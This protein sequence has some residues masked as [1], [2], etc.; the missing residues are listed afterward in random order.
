MTRATTALSGDLRVAAEHALLAPSIHNTQPW[1]FV[2]ADGAL[3]I[4]ADRGRQLSVLDP[5]GRQLMISCGCAVFNA[6]VSLA[7]AGYDVAVER[8]PDPNR[9][10]LVARLR[11]PTHTAQWLRLGD[12]D[13]YVIHRQT[14]RRHFDDEQVHPSVVHDLVDAVSAEGARLLQ[15]TD[16]GQLQSVA[17]LSQRADELENIE[18]AYRAELRSWTSE[19]PKRRDGVP[20]MA[21]P[22]VTGNAHDDI[23]IR[24]FDTHGMGWL[25]T[26]TRS[27]TSQCLL[28]LSTDGDNQLAWLRAGEALEHL[29]LQATRLGYVASLFTQ[30]IEVPSTRQ[31]LRTELKLAVNPQLLI[32]VGRASKTAAS[33]RRQLDDV[34]VQQS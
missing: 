25:P 10:D 12:L 29:W 4:H 2:I 3:E 27:S 7:A 15:I 33:M 11:L 19:D 31:Q 28:I 14:N 32:R 21:V 1:R 26:E 16:P 9:P 34:L 30:L 23:P 18:P 22:R 5:T 17:R 8:L 13:N 24:D 20:A 6:R